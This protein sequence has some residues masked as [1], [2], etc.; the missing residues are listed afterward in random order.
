VDDATISPVNEKY[1]AEE[2][3]EM[4]LPVVQL[5]HLDLISTLSI[6]PGSSTT[7]VEEFT[8]DSATVTESS[9]EAPSEAISEYHNADSYEARTE[10]PSSAESREVFEEENSATTVASEKLREGDF[11]MYATTFA[12]SEEEQKAREGFGEA[13]EIKYEEEVGRTEEPPLV[14]EVEGR[15]DDGS[16]EL[17]ESTEAPED[18]EVSAELK[19]GVTE[20]YPAALREDQE[21][22]EVPQISAEFRHEEDP[23]DLELETQTT[24]PVPTENEI[25]A[26]MRT[27]EDEDVPETFTSTSTENSF[28]TTT[29]F[30]GL[31]TATST[32][33]DKYESATKLSSDAPVP[34]VIIGKIME[35]STEKEDE[36]KVTEL[37]A[38]VLVQDSS[39]DGSNA[40]VIFLTTTADPKVV[41]SVETVSIASSEGGDA[42][43]AEIRLEETSGGAKNSSELKIFQVLYSNEEDEKNEV[44]TS[45]GA[46]SS[47]MLFLPQLPRPLIPPATAIGSNEW[48]AAAYEETKDELMAGLWHEALDI[49]TGGR[50]AAIRAT[51]RKTQNS[52]FIQ[53]ND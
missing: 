29:T 5:E 40:E 17:K 46:D 7:T 20:G 52:K 28:T 31:S 44:T 2:Q 1:L 12:P 32:F 10:E 42:V 38:E 6:N 27:S 25:S 47:A 21:S 45:R 50:A 33:D 51:A 53:R 30:E 23:Q 43:G 41:E 26:E 4:S 16:S 9:V 48:K 19:D 13:Q 8:K 11:E 14:Q 3:E 49:L 35:D 15:E 37:N 34:D 39:L 22:T 18:A 24:E 36:P